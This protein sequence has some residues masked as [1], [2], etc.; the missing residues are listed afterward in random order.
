MGQTNMLDPDMTSSPASLIFPI[1][2]RNWDTRLEGSQSGTFKITS[3]E[4]EQRTKIKN[5]STHQRDTK[6]AR[7]FPFHI[8]GNLYKLLFREAFRMERKLLKHSAS[9]PLQGLMLHIT[10]SIPQSTHALLLD[11]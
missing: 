5:S 11:K 2:G 1:L 6:G 10:E 9:L 8:N 7:M 3:A 4:K